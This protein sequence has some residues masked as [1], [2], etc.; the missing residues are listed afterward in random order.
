MQSYHTMLV[1]SVDRDVPEPLAVLLTAE[2]L[3]LVWPLPLPP[4]AC[5]IDMSAD[6]LLVSGDI[7]RL[8]CLT[9]LVNCSPHRVRSLGE[10]FCNNPFTYCRSSLLPWARRLLLHSAWKTLV[11]STGTRCRVVVMWVLSGSSSG[12]RGEGWTALRGKRRGYW[13]WGMLRTGHGLHSRWILCI[14][15][16]GSGV[17]SGILCAHEYGVQKQKKGGV[18]RGGV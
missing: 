17:P 15:W 4:R 7:Q 11:V 10:A 12:A 8:H 16:S 2:P 1:A 9:A 6:L 5:P 14:F 3:L 13:L 18:L